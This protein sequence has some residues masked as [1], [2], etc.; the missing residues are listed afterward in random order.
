MVNSNTPRTYPLDDDPPPPVSAVR[1][2]LPLKACPLRRFPRN[3][4]SSVAPRRRDFHASTGRI[5]PSLRGR[6]GD[7]FLSR[8][9]W[10][11]VAST[12]PG[13][14]V[15]SVSSW[16]HLPLAI[17]QT[18]SPVRGN[19]LQISM[20]RRHT[21]SSLQPTLTEREPSRQRHKTWRILWH[22]QLAMALNA[23]FSTLTIDVCIRT[24]RL[25]EWLSAA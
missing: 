6:R 14:V 9:A 22:R 21:P 17:T 13:H 8:P 2:D 19:L 10:M 5:R 18:G 12:S 25:P 16:L 23:E 15:R 4:S 20:T 7:N 11:G 24:Y 1:W 3:S